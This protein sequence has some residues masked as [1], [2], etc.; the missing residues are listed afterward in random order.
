MNLDTL[1]EKVFINNEA[2]A[3][4]NGKQLFNSQAQGDAHAK[5]VQSLYAPNTGFNY[6]NPQQMQDLNRINTQQYH[7]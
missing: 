7:D 1:C 5:R 3:N 2:N 6:H 4:L